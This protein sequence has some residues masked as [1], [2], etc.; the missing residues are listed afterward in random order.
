MGRGICRLTA[1]QVARLAKK[2]GMYCDGGGLYLRVSSATAASWAYRYM[3]QGKL[4]RQQLNAGL[5]EQ[6]NTPARPKATELGL[7]RFPDISL[8]EARE[9]AANFRKLKG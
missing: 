2:P 3:L 6:P 5:A 1:L 7:G 8:S 4:R 9:L